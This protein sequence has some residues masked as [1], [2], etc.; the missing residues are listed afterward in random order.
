MDGHRA[1]I[2]LMKTA[3]AIAAFQGRIRIVAEDMVEAA[4]MVMPHRMRKRPFEEE[5]F[6]AEAIRTLLGDFPEVTHAP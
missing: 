1:D 6:D 4:M 3:M 2:M 5:A